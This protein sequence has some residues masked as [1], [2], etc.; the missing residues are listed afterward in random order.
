VTDEAFA[1][2]VGKIHGGGPALNKASYGE[3][4]KQS[5][6]VKPFGYKSVDT[7][8]FHDI[9]MGTIAPAPGPAPEGAHAGREDAGAGRH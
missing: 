6:D 9:A 7:T 3:L 1:A 2:W 5:S 8:L 4:A